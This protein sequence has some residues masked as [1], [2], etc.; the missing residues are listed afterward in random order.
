[1][2]A[3]A[4][5]IKSGPILE[6]PFVEYN[7]DRQVRPIY[8]KIRRVR[9]KRGWLLR[10][11]GRL[12]APDPTPEGLG[13]HALQVGEYAY[14]LHTDEANQKYLIVQRLTDDQIWESTVSHTIVGYT[15]LSDEDIQ[16]LCE[17]Y[18]LQPIS[19]QYD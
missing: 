2:L 5:S 6:H 4:G 7:L 16:I 3:L 19:K 12:L 10:R 11:C 9:G 1:M 13:H 8:L 14:E 17:S 15:D 18:P